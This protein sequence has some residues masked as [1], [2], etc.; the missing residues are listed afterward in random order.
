MVSEPCSGM[1]STTFCTCK[2][3]LFFYSTL[4]SWILICINIFKTVC[5]GSICHRLLEQGQNSD[6]KFL[7][8]GQ[9]FPAHKCILSARSEYFTDMF[10]TKWKDKNLITLKHPLVDTNT[11]FCGWMILCCCFLSASLLPHPIYNHSS[12]LLSAVNKSTFNFRWTLQPLQQSCNI[13]IQVC[14]ETLDILV[15]TVAVHETRPAD[16]VTYMFGRE[17]FT[18]SSNWGWGDHF[19]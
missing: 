6:V 7:V 14:V 8:H 12:I 19:K 15:L 3:K 10:E 18:A 9:I 4:V 2:R 16:F 5:I 11:H 1:I 13:S 17:L